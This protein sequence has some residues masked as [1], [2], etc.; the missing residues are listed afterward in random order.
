MSAWCVLYGE[1]GGRR[2]EKEEG[3]VS[4]QRE[5]KVEKNG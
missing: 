5:K 2:G 1:E 4:K 3:Y